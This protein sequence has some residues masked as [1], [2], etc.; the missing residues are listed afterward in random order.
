MDNND[1]PIEPDTLKA[2]MEWA[3]QNNFSVTTQTEPMKFSSPTFYQGY[4]M[5]AQELVELYQTVNN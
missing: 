4:E 3:M 5:T 2:V 1:L